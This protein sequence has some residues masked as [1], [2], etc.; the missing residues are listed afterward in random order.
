MVLV[1]TVPAAIPVMLRRPDDSIVKL[2]VKGKVTPC[3]RSAHPSMCKV[4][5]RL[6][7]RVRS[8][9]PSVGRQ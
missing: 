6:L 8:S 3:V 9:G 7:V 2:P 4:A 5:S 1:A